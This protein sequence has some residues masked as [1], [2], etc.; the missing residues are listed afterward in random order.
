VHVIRRRVS[1]ASAHIE[2][3]VVNGGRTAIRSVDEIESLA[4][5]G[6]SKAPVSFVGP[7]PFNSDWPALSCR[8][9]HRFSSDSATDGV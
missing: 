9:G 1:F 4:L 5:R 2:G 8:G 7:T 3:L 6:A